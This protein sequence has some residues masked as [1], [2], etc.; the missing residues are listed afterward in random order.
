MCVR[1]C[2]EQTGGS[3]LTALLPQPKLAAGQLVSKSTPMAT[4]SSQNMVPYSLSRHGRAALG[5][6]RELKKKGKQGAVAKDSRNH[7]NSDSD[8]EDGPVSFF[9]HLH[10]SH[11]Q[12]EAETMVGVASSEGV[13]SGPDDR[14]KDQIQAAPSAPK[15]FSKEAASVD[16]SDIH[17]SLVTRLW[18]ES[19]AGSDDYIQVAADSEPD[20]RSHPLPAG[21]PLSGAGPGL[22]MDDEAV[23]LVCCW[24]AK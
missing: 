23:S 17:P 21:T 2:T 3:G 20:P 14:H 13:A 8:D 9:S 7:E 22:S 11:T 24:R 19:V 12:P 6:R 16:H 4:P 5:A 10:S 15:P 1:D 18:E